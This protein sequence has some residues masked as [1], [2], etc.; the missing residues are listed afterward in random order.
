[1]K[2]VI[3][4][5]LLLV[6]CEQHYPGIPSI[7]FEKLLSVCNGDNTA[8]ELLSDEQLILLDRHIREC[9]G[10]VIQTPNKDM[11]EEF[12]PRILDL[13]ASNPLSPI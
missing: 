3:L 8:R 5:F 4:I 1:M 11:D 6:A 13:Q 2:K 12:F 9:R 10:E 7:E